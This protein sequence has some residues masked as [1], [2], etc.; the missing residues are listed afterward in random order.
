M[1]DFWLVI[2]FQPYLETLQTFFSYGKRKLLF[3]PFEVGWLSPK[4]A[5]I[6]VQPKQPSDVIGCITLMPRW[7][8]RVIM[9]EENTFEASQKT[10][11]SCKADNNSS[12]RHEEVESWSWGFSVYLIGYLQDISCK[13]A[14]EC[15]FLNRKMIGTLG[16]MTSTWLNN[17]YTYRIKKD[18]KTRGSSFWKHYPECCC[19]N[20][21]NNASSFRVA[22]LRGNRTLCEFHRGRDCATVTFSAVVSVTSYKLSQ[23]QQ[24]K[25]PSSFVWRERI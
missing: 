2:K 14:N 6:L 21:S 12:L 16:E 10:S 22:S 24:F 19:V 3:Q 1:W 23:Q 8:F 11:Q 25:K 5:A 15:K 17:I 13:Q 18:M 20:R 7:N 4:L 9:G